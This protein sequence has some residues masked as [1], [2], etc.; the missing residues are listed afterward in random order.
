MEPVLICIFVLITGACIGSFLNV[1]ALRAL[2]KESIVLPASKCP[3]CSSPIKWYDNIPVFSYLFTF[4]GKCRSCGCRVSLQYPAVEALT[5]VIF[6]LVFLAFGFTVKT[7]LLLI[8]FCTAIVIMITDIK[9]EYVFES[10]AWILIIFSIITSLYLNGLE[11]YIKPAIGL[12][13]GVIA[14]EGAARLAYYLIRKKEDKKTEEEDNKQE[15]PAEN[16]EQQEQEETEPDINDENFDI[17]EYIKKNKRAF[18]EGDTYLAAAAG[19]LLGWEYLLLAMF[20]AVILQA[21]CVLPVFVI[22]LYRQ[23]HFRLIF[24][25]SAFFAIAFLYWI[26]S[27]IIE[28]N[29]YAAMVFAVILLFFAIDAINR[30]KQTVNNQ[31]FSAVPFGPALLT[32]YFAVFFFGNNIAQFMFKHIFI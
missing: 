31:G 29:L 5:A 13:A 27:N 1:A 24:S 28:L 11:N 3:E 20:L 21:L 19:A 4:K 2:S 8:L 12:I 15:A 30:L 32:A 9:K 18:G 26:I 6:L 7:L 16:H 14:M 10:H 25:L 23:K 22:N 17:N